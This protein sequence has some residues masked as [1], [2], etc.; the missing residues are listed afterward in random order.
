MDSPPSIRQLEFESEDLHKAEAVAAALGYRQT[1][2]TSS[3]DLWGLYC[4]PEN[5]EHAK[6]PIRGGC[7]IKTAQFG[8][9][10]VQYL[11]DLQL[12]DDMDR[13]IT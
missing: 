5:P 8:L 9:M 3:S 2:Y 10:F 6:G 12:K 13:E 1:A 7:I 11:E 4:L